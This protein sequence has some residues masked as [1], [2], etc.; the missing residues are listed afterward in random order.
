MGQ[1]YIVEKLSQL[2]GREGLA[3]EECHVVYIMVE[4]RKLIDKDRTALL[5]AFPL[6]KFYADWSVHTEKGRVTPEIRTAA[7]QVYAFSVK[8][9]NEKY[10]GLNETSPLEAFAHGHDLRTELASF[11]AHFGLP[12]GIADQGWI[13]FVECLIRVL[14][15]QPI[16]QP[17][18]DI[19]R[20]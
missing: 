19:A 17:T 3:L 13:N 7:E 1:D 12:S 14:E 16:L 18:N 20:M 5:K 10:P 9:I 4:I 8:R 15:D 2:L 11:V 6:L